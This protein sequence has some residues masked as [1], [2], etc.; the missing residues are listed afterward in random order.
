M[1]SKINFLMNKI[2]LFTAAFAVM[3]SLSGCSDTELAN[4]DT[5][6]EK[7]PI[8]FHTVGSQMGSRAEIINS[9]DI[10][11]TDFKVYAFDKD[12]NAFMGNNDNTEQDAYAHNGVRIMYD[13]TN[14]TWKYANEADIRYWPEN[15]HLDFYAV[16]PGPV[17]T[18]QNEYDLKMHYTWKINKEKQQ[19]TYSSFDEYK[20]A[21]GNHNLDVMYAVT[22]DQTKANG[23]VNLAFKH[24][25]SQIVFQAKTQYE[26][27]EVEI[28][29]IK[30]YNCKPSGTFTFPTT[31]SPELKDW[32]SADNLIGP[33]PFTVVKDQTIT[34]NSVT[35]TTDISSKTPLLLVPQELNNPWDTNKTKQEADKAF[36]SYLEITCK[37]MQNGV[38]LVG[39]A[40]KYKTL[41]VPFQTT[42]EPG[43]RYVYT[44]IFGGGYTDQGEQILTPINFTASADE[45]TADKGNSTN[46]N[47]KV[48]Q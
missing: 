14:N 42:W 18:E 11:K 41:Y 23:K 7:T 27:M 47:D 20:T 22:K 32:Q 5:A 34:V 30:I 21:G 44:L 25:L 2:Y 6:Q 8:G 28:K 16:N 29:E 46:E 9:G 43:K 39:A 12:G 4:I 3:A 10:T 1:L 31:E 45:W 35:K 36:Q 38:Y 15:T 26:G 13:Q 48:I 37:I 40:D 24:I 19:I 33:I 17:V